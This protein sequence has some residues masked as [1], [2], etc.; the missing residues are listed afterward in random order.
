MLL[1]INSGARMVE[2]PL[3][4]LPRVGVSSVTGNRLVAIRVGLRM[5][6]LILRVRRRS[7]RRGCGHPRS[8]SRAR[9]PAARRMSSSHFD[10]IAAVYDDV[11]ATPRRRALSATSECGSSSIGARRG[12]ALDVGCGTGVLASRLADA[13]YA[14]T[15]VDPS[16]G[17][18]DDS[19][20]A[21]R[22]RSCAVEG[23]GTALPFDADALRPRSQRGD[24]SPHRRPGEVRRTLAEM[25]RVARPG[26]RILVWDHNPRNP[27]WG[28]LMARVSRRTRGAERLIPEGEVLDGLRSGGAEIMLAAQLGL[29]PD[30]VP[31]RRAARGGGG[32]ARR[33]ADA[34]DP[35]GWAPTTSCSPR[36]RAEPGY[37]RRAMG[38]F[39]RKTAAEA[40]PTTRAR[41]HRG[42]LR[43]EI[44][45]LTEA[46]RARPDRATER[47][48]LRLRHLAGRAP[49]R[50]AGAARPSTRRPT[51][52]GCRRST[53][54]PR[55]RPPTL[56]PGCCAP[57]SCATA[58]CWCA[59]SSAATEAL[60]L[61]AEIDRAFAERAAFDAGRAPAAGY[62]EEFEPEAP[63]EV[64]V[65]PW[66]KQGGGMLAADSPKLAFRM[67]ELFEAAGLP[68][69]V[70]GYLGEPPLLSV[71]KTTLRKADPSVGGAWHQDGAFM[72]DARALNLWLSLSRCGDEAPGST[73]S[74]A[75]LDEIVV[76]HEAMLDVELTRAKA[77]EAA[78]DLAILR[79]IFEPG[80]ALFFDEMFLH[81]TG[82]D[83]V[84][85]EPAIRGRELVLRRLRVPG[86][87]TRRSPSRASKTSTSIRLTPA[88]VRV[89]TRR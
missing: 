30:F 56:T 45:R 23:S 28:H 15:G 36:S 50:R 41:E 80:D 51:R 82:S 10:E 70:E 49:A 69:L 86:R 59:A 1:A 77:R 62:Y 26:G 17:M 31:P 73:S 64:A 89:A 74:R 20:R 4:Y 53:G 58:A 85:A 47:R 3:N 67:L 34:A 39:K 78:G 76:E 5:V 48:L 32:R 9:R 72:G 2:V 37:D 87:T 63:F 42:S 16:P 68:R 22:R 19:P 60:E 24:V 40:A 27:Y 44:R 18:L 71:H 57:A 11:A 33:R 12:R 25:V 75:A 29:V 46:N 52:P 54:C 14:M 83:P 55:S 38:L 35:A 79:P 66:I 81:Q 61:A 21:Q 8:P 65:R 84:D 6:Q 43:A 13:G 88:K 7:P